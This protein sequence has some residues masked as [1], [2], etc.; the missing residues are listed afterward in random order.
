LIGLGL[1]DLAVDEDLASGREVGLLRVG[2][3]LA[4]GDFII[5]SRHG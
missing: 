2:K 3:A 5:R 1:P 4:H